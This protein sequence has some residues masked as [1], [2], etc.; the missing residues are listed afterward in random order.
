MILVLAI[1][2]ISFTGVWTDGTR[3]DVETFGLKEM[4]YSNLRPVM[5]T[6]SITV[7]ESCPKE[8]LYLAIGVCREYL[9]GNRNWPCALIE[10]IV[11]WKN[12]KCSVSNPQLF[13]LGSLGLTPEPIQIG[14]V[15]INR[16][17]RAGVFPAFWR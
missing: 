5:A 3:P 2:V 14:V 17:L 10:T 8:D 4:S 7:G 12:N 16:T 1:W 13:R 11:V 6:S 9:I 15:L